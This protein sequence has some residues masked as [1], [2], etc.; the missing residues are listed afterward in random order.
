[1]IGGVLYLL[2]AFVPMFV[3][4]AAVL[5]MPETAQA[6]L[7]DDPQKV[8]PTLVMERMPLV[9][10]VPSLVRCCRPSCPRRRPRCWRHRPPSSRT[11][12]ATCAQA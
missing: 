7:K 1:V 5:I 10:Q 4:T 9:L 12:C 3:V 11:S 8:L 6:L 2:F